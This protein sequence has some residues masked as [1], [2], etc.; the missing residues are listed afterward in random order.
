MAGSM[1]AKLIEQNSSL[2]RAAVRGTSWTYIAFYS[3]K[4]MVFFSMIVLA[5]LLTRD[6]FGVVG[7][8]LAILG[9]LDVVKDL[10]IGSAVIYYKDRQVADTAFWLNLGTGVSLFVLVWALAPLISIYFNDPRA[11]Q[12]TRV[13][14][15]S[16]PLNALG[17]T[18]EAL[19]I[20]DL[21]FGK[22]FL[23]DIARAITKGVIAISLAFMGFGPWSLIYSQLAG[24]SISVI[25]LW[26]LVRWRPSTAFDA[27]GARSLLTF[28]L[29]IV[30]MNLI[31]AF[32][33][34]V[35]YLLVGRYLGSEALGVYALAFR[36]PELTIL[37]FCVIVAQ[38]V[39]PVF[40]KMRDDIGALKVG[41][42]ETA[43]YVALITVPVG[44]GMAL[45]AEPFVLAFFGEKWIDAAPVMRAIAI[46]SLLISLGFNAGDVYKAQGRPGML[47]R[48]SILHV[49]LLV[50]ALL[51]AVRVS[52]SVIT[53]GWVQA[54]IAFI[55]SAV[56]LLVAL[57]MINISVS[58]LFNSLKPPVLPGIG[59]AGAVIG[60][61]N[62]SG[63]LSPWIQLMAGI[64]CGAVAYFGV[65]F[66]VERPLVLATVRLVQ[67]VIGSRSE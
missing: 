26:R 21:Q 55:L 50:P 49:V 42:L 11:A 58:Q 22:K 41:F 27:E 15:L 34:N 8:A 56:Y 64:S 3:G 33:L 4:L 59:L 16:F 28:G 52:A 6:D 30:G 45:L 51:W 39:F 7:Y 43:R 20:K 60:V 53:V 63:D 61:L 44:L 13:L 14:A 32:A 62:I 25:V 40:N 5:R 46:Y 24:V 48:I 2:A 66:V 65:L 31:S 37:Q 18:H 9:F 29:P 23:P 35:D 1:S 17:S 57:K 12:V 10:G 54:S 47:T 67:S 38:V 36:I 19:L